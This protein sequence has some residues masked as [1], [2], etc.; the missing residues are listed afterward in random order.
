MMDP[1]SVVL[2]GIVAVALA[3]TLIAS[4]LPAA[5]AFTVLMGVVTA[6]AQRA[7]RR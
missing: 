2:F 7:A 4:S 6:I 3:S 1:L 5:V